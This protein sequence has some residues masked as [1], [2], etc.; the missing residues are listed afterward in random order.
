MCKLR[1]RSDA[2][3]DQ[4]LGEPVIKAAFSTFLAKSGAERSLKFW[5]ACRHFNQIP[6]DD[7]RKRLPRAKDIFD[8]YLHGANRIKIDKPT[9]DAIRQCVSRKAKGRIFDL[10]AEKVFQRL[11]FEYMP[12][13]L[14]SDDF[15][16]ISSKTRSAAKLKRAAFA[17]VR[18]FACVELIRPN[19]CCFCIKGSISHIER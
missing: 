8:Q 16:S 1:S 12:R 19:N 11:K 18:L 6:F 17:H 4:L 9:I 10:A 3:L 15:T 5:D 7:D 13:F 2:S 14:L